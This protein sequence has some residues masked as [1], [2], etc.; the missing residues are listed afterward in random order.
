MFLTDPEAG[1]REIRRVLRP[2]G[3]FATAAWAGAEEN[4]WSSVV[5]QVLG[6][7]PA[8]PGAPGQFALGE[9]GGLRDLI[10]AAGFVEDIEVE[11]ID[12]VLEESFADWWARTAVMSRSG[13]ALHGREEEVRA[14]LASYEADGLLRLP[15]RTWVAAATA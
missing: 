3:R 12:L 1:V 2:G 15:A 11:A 7:T 9:Q 14:A 6:E 4:P 8:E 13:A 5:G 10:E